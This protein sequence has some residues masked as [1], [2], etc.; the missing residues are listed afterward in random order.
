M[1]NQY[2]SFAFLIVLLSACQ[3]EQDVKENPDAA[4]EGSNFKFYSSNELYQKNKLERSSS[5]SG[6]FEIVDVTLTQ[7]VPGSN[8]DHLTIT[9]QNDSSCSGEFELIWDGMVQY[10]YPPRTNILIRFNG[11]CSKEVNTSKQTVIDVDLDEFTGNSDLVEQAVFSVI[12]GS[13]ATSDSDVSA[14][15]SNN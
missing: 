6:P 4:K 14:S 15:V 7:N 11:A 13:K 2:F 10:S 12:N 8:H 9:V 1:R 3:G 5:T